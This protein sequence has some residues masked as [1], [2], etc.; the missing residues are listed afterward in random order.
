MC[1]KVKVILLAGIIISAFLCC[2]QE[3]VMEFETVFEPGKQYVVYKI[4]SEITVD[5]KADEVEWAQAQWSEDFE[6]IEGDKKPEPTYRTRMKMLWDET[7]LYILAELEEPHIWAYYNK[8]DMIVYHENDFEVFIDPDRDTHNYFEFE[9]NAQNTLFDL[10]MNKPYR[11]G[12]KANIEWNAKGF[13]SAVS[14]DGTLNDSGDVDKRWTVEMAIPFSSLTLDGPFKQPKE[15]DVWKINFSRVEWQ[16]D[17]I[18]GKYVRKK[19]PETKKLIP[20]NNWVWSPQGLINMHY[21][22]RWGM[23]QFSE[24]PVSGERVQFALPE[25]EKWA[26]YLWFIYDKQLRYRT[27]FSTYAPTLTGLKIPET[28]SKDG[29]AYSLKLESDEHNYVAT[30]ITA[31]GL[32][33]SINEQGLLTSFKSVR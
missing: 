24:N 31:N 28:G 15:S 26:N 9:M 13:K 6:D 29:V 19:V 2:S 27:V 3:R 7:N 4:L 21:P 5:G 20:E 14:I 17:L 30:L 32:R 22:E 16:T 25:E 12:G 1:L 33:I 10:F 18:D 23:L 8:N 11:N